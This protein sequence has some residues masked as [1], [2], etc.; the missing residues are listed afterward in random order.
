MQ[1][2]KVR[3]RHSGWR[4]AASVA[5]RHPFV[6]VQARSALPHSTE[7]TRKGGGFNGVP[8][9]Q[10][11]S[12]KGNHMRALVDINNTTTVSVII[13]DHDLLNLLGKHN[14]VRRMRKNDPSGAYS[15]PVIRQRN[16][17]VYIRLEVEA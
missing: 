4:V 8:T 6:V 5:A 16:D 14:E 3:S 17:D 9:T 12:R 2:T 1:Q 7:N 11:S 10:F 13:S 15:N